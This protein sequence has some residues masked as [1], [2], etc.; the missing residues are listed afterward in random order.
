MPLVYPLKNT[1]PQQFE[2]PIDHQVDQ[3]VAAG[4]FAQKSTTALGS[5]TSTTGIAYDAGNAFLVIKTEGTKIS[6]QVAGNEYAWLDN[7]GILNASKLKAVTNLYS[8]NLDPA[9]GVALVIGA[10]NATSI[11][12]GKSGLPVLHPGGAQAGAMHLNAAIP[13]APAN[14]DIWPDGAD[15][16]VRSGGVAQNL[17][18]LSGYRQVVDCGFGVGDGTA[19]A[20]Q[21]Q[22]SPGCA[23]D[24]MGTWQNGTKPRTNLF[25]YSQQLDNAY[26]S[27]AGVAVTADAAT[28][29]DGTSTADLIS[30]SDTQGSRSLNKGGL[31]IPIQNAPYT[32]SVYVKAS[33]N[34]T[35]CGVGF[36][37][38]SGW[39]SDASA[40]ILSGPGSATISGGAYARVTGLSQSAWTRV[41]YT[42]TC[43][44]TTTFYFYPD[45]SASVVSGNGN[46][47]WGF[48]FETGSIA[49]EYIPT[50]SAVVTVTP[51]YWPAVGDGFEPV[52]E[53]DGPVSIFL[54][55]DWQGYRQLYSTSRT[56]LLT[57]SQQFDNAAWSKT[58]CTVT[59]NAT[60]APDGTSTADTLIEDTTTSYHNIAQTVAASGTVV[61]LSA[62]LK[63]GTQTTAWMGDAG[64]A[65][66]LDINLSTG[67]VSNIG[68][69][70]ISYGIKSAGSGWYRAWMTH[71]SITSL[72]IGMGSVLASY[73]GTGKTLYVWGAQLETGSVA[74]S[75]I[76]TTTAPV[77]VTDY[78]LAP[79]GLVTL[80]TAPA[81]GAVLSWSGAYYTTDQEAY[82]DATGRLSLP[83]TD[84][85][86]TPGSVT[87]NS[88]TGQFAVAA[89]SAS[90]TV[91]N[92]SVSATSVVLCVIQSADA[93]LTGIVSVVPGAGSFTF[94]GN[95]AATAACKVGF[96]VIN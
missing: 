20:F 41:A 94:T 60:V 6:L 14:G 22:W 54:D 59:A 71:A 8:P 73:L 11:T 51:A 58:A 82:F 76:P 21:L 62:F 36:V 2:G 34:S 16:I 75:Y 78:T 49:T 48:Q 87:I 91:T 63:A 50:T 92:S 79:G 61:T 27:K 12:I 83:A 25:Q 47:A 18:T 80:A 74:T 53:P 57:Y 17:S 69:N 66:S 38:G 90:A 4:F 85:S 29:P 67:T 30:K 64:T 52:Y 65:N 93:T 84:S 44:G 28:A 26:W 70:V 96:I 55:R 45:T 15:V 81:A 40:K 86:G 5:P 9:T 42:G 19:T 23:S 72:R 10:T 33:P 3:L 43:A 88:P 37:T 89:G 68:A 77:T 1:D 56:N 31:T 13:T 35:Q 39:P 95:A 24:A 46:Y 32:F 7:A